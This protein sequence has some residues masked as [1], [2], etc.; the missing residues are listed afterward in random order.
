MLIAPPS[1]ARFGKNDAE[2]AHKDVAF[3]LSRF[4]VAAPLMPTGCANWREGSTL[5]EYQSQLRPVKNGASGA[6]RLEIE[7]AYDPHCSSLRRGKRRTGLHLRYRQK[8]LA[9]CLSG[10]AHLESQRVALFERPWLSSVSHAPVTTGP[11]A[12]QAVY[13]QAN[14]E[15][16]SEHSATAQE[17]AAPNAG[18]TGSDGGLWNQHPVRRGIAESIVGGALGAASQATVKR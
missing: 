2:R 1:L 7:S 14:Q 17:T 3:R 6:K 9:T 8:Q 11:D 12:I 10:S 18:S 5:H 15:A 4:C 13:H 16:V